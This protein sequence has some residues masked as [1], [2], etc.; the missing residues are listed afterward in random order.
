[1]YSYQTYNFRFQLLRHKIVSAYNIAAVSCNSHIQENNFP[2]IVL[3]QYKAKTYFGFRNLGVIAKFWGV[4][5]TLKNGIKKHCPA[6]CGVPNESYENL[7]AT[8]TK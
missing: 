8:K 1:M 4:I 3:L 6:G 7:K 2:Q 5:F